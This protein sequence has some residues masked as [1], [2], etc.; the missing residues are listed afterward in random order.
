MKFLL[1]LLCSALSLC[2]LAQ[3]NTTEATA[4]D[5]S[6]VQTDTTVIEFTQVHVMPKFKGGMSRFYQ[7]LN[8]NLEYPKEAKAAGIKGRVF[9]TFIVEK[10][11]S[12]SNVK[13][14]RKLGHGCDEA[15]VD[16][17]KKLV[18]EGPAYYDKSPVRMLM[19]IPVGFGI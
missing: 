5:Q 8:S 7:K 19:N 10:D 9:L 6:K 14:M 4:A 3:G 12:I 15:A 18:F 13:V 16:A 1:T 17:L 2:C 11:G